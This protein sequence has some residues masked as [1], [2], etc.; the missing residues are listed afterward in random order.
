MPELRGI[1]QIKSVRN[2]MNYMAMMIL[3]HQVTMVGNLYNMNVVSNLI[4]PPLAY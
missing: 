3:I 2:L 1:C 4:F